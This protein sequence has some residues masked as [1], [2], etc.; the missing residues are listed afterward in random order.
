MA[1]EEAFHLTK[2]ELQKSWDSLNQL[3]NMSSTS[4]LFILK[5]T[6]KNSDEIQPGAKGLMLAMG[7]AFCS[8]LCLLEKA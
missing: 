7:P 2:K 6:L 3:G 1:M 8:E 4:V 5:E